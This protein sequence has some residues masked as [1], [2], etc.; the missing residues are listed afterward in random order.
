MHQGGVQPEI[1]FVADVGEAA[2]DAKTGAFVEGDGGWIV[3]ADDGDHLAVTEL[4]A[5]F[6]QSVH[7]GEAGALTHAL[8]AT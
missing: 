5:T 7:E 2:G 3:A 8:C 4:R 1:E 6:N